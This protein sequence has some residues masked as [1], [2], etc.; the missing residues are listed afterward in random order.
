MRA[1]EAH[2]LISSA[3]TGQHM[4]IVQALQDP[5]P[6][7]RARTHTGAQDSDAHLVPIGDLLT[8]G[9]VSR[10]SRFQDVD[11]LLSASGLN[12]CLLTDLDPQMRRRWDDFI[13]LTTPFPDWAALLRAASAEWV[14]RRIGIIID[15]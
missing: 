12:P 10:H 3:L 1:V 2:D 14:I 8:A 5:T 7:R 6:V 4:Q 11:A 15:A 13:R 9:F